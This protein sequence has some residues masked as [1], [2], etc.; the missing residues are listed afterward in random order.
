MVTI[1]GHFRL[2]QHRLARRS[3][4]VEAAR[5]NRGRWLDENPCEVTEILPLDGFDFGDPDDLHDFGDLDELDFSN[6]AT[7]DNEAQVLLS[8][9]LGAGAAGI[10]F[11]I[12]LLCSGQSST[13]TGTL[14]GQIVMEGF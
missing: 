13:L 14:A 2:S 11:A 12:A 4:A 1:R 7:F 9:L 6:D 10:V 3:S 5:V 8:P